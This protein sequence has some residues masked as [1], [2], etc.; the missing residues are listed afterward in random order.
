MRPIV[1]PLK[2]PMR[3]GSS[4]PGIFFNYLG[5]SEPTLGERNPGR[6]GAE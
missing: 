5:I 3:L 6:P 1:A 4:P 2:R